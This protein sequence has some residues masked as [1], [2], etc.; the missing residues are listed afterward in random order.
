MIFIFNLFL[1]FYSW[2]FYNQRKEDAMPKKK[3]NKIRETIYFS[4]DAYAVLKKLHGHYPAR[5][6][7][8]FINGA[9]LFLDKEAVLGLDANCQPVNP[10][11][12]KHVI[13]EICRAEP[14]VT[15]PTKRDKNS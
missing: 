8:D 13:R 1:F 10:L 12:Y 4:D 7:S 6:L 5:I 14:D 11:D 9:V 15:V 2:A 3:A